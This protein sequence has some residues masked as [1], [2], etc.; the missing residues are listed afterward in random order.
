[1][2]RLCEWLGVSFKLFIASLLVAFTGSLSFHFAGD[3][4]FQVVCGIFILVPAFYVQ[5]NA[6]G[7][8]FERL[9]KVL[10]AAA[11]SFIFILIGFETGSFFIN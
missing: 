10:F 11:V 3:G 7:D 6:S 5:I 9:I 8:Y 2:K 1:M 4:P